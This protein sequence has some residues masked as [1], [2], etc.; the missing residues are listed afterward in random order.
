MFTEFS[1]IVLSV[2]YEEEEEIND[3]DLHERFFQIVLVI[4][5]LFLKQLPS[6]LKL[7]DKLLSTIKSKII[8]D[9]SELELHEIK[10]CIIDI[11]NSS[12]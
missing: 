10:N 6:I 12:I 11:L 7:E 9:Y 1:V 3:L 2:F 5:K 8:I 4:P